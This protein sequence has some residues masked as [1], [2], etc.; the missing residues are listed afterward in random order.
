MDVVGGGGGGRQ[1]GKP[2]MSYNDEVWHRHTLP[3]EGSKN[4]CITS[5]PLSSP[6]ICNFFNKNQQIL[7]Y[8]E[9]KMKTAFSYKNSNSFNFFESVK[10]FLINMFTILMMLT[11]M[12]TLG[13]LRK[14]IFW[15]KYCDVIISV[16]DV[17]HKNLSRDSSYTVDVVMWPKFD[18]SSISM[19]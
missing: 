13:F 4:L 3:K 2:Q 7:L 16:H 10:I 14:K 5:H 17:T 11:K 15:N 19:R 6:D 9:T 18:K 1:G 8:Q 12:A